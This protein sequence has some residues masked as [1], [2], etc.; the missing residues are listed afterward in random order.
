[1]RKFAAISV[2]KTFVVKEILLKRLNKYRFE[3]DLKYQH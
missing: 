3:E 2:N 1:M